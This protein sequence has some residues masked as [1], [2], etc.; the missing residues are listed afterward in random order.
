MESIILCGMP[1]SGKTTA[2]QIIAKRLRIKAMGGTD[3]L[4]QMAKERGYKMTGDDWWDTEEGVKFLKE[5]E[6]NPN[7]D[8]ETDRRLLKLIAKGN[9]V[10][11]SY[12]APWLSKKGFKCWLN[13]SAQ[14]RAQR[15]AK[16]DGI[17]I[18]KSIRST[19]IRDRENRK[20]YKKLYKIDFGHDMKPF[21]LVIGTDN[22]TSARVATLIIKGLKSKGIK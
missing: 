10:V 11:T 8:R 18:S 12:T 14:K 20:L 22:L 21:D 1:A 19:R 17:P 6:T 16:R 5:R 13:A 2:A 15:M 9:V 7:F 4:K 3:I